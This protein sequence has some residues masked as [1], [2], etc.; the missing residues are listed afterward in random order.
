MVLPA[1]SADL[2]AALS[3]RHR[4]IGCDNVIVL[5]APS[6]DAT[7][8]V[9]RTQ[10]VN[11]DGREVESCGNATRCVAWLEAAKQAS[12]GEV[13]PQHTSF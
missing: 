9:V 2:C 3:D 7:G 4:G 5:H 6:N 11:V 8:A 1:V 12:V 13:R 10:I